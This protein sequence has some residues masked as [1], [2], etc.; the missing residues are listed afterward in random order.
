MLRYEDTIT[1]SELVFK[2]RLRNNPCLIVFVNNKLLFRDLKIW[3][4]KRIRML[5]MRNKRLVRPPVT[6]LPSLKTP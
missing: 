6:S 3:I 1:L 4:R 2:L 5:E